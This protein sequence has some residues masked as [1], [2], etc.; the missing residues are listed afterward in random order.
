MGDQKER[1]R[2]SDTERSAANYRERERQREIERGVLLVGEKGERG[3]CAANSRPEGE[4]EI[5]EMC[6]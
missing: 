1:E 5:V 2:E 3:R 6:C 4:R